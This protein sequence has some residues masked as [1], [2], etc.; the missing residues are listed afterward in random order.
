[1]TVHITTPWAL[2]R[3]VPDIDEFMGSV[4]R[5]R[6]QVLATCAEGVAGL[7]TEDDIWRQL[8]CGLLSRPY[9]AAFGGT[10]AGAAMPTRTRLV[11]GHEV[12][13]LVDVRGARR[14]FESGATLKFNRIDHWH[15]PI[16]EMVDELAEFLDAGVVAHAFLSPPGDEPVITAHLDGVHV[17]ILQTAGVKDWVAGRLKPDLPSGSVFCGDGDLDQVG[18]LTARLRP[19]AVLYLPHGS[20]H[21]ALARSEISL[22]VAIEVL[23]PAPWDYV[24]AYS[25]HV[26]S[27]ID[28]A[29]ASHGAAG[30]LERFTSALDSVSHQDILPEAV[31]TVSS[32]TLVAAHHLG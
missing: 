25:S 7:L 29:P 1:M 13:D 4:W 14:A 30:F 32:R 12:D 28:R 15:L 8:D 21:Y 10:P 27:A 23:D 31:R 22:H 20:P 18:R 6:P 3:L 26:R 5:R 19:G 17:L 9:V 24:Q 11:E 2:D 16:R